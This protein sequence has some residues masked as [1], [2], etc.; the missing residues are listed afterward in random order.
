M[1]CVPRITSSVIFVSELSRSVEYY[2]DVFSCT[3]SVQNL[4]SALMLTPA[5]FQ[6]Y[7]IARGN[8]ASHLLG[9]IGYQCLIWT[10]ES[11]AELDEL[12]QV[13]S[14]R[15]HYTYSR[16]THGVRF[17]TTGDPD[18]IRILVAHPSPEELPRSVVDAVLYV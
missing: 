6:I 9:G 7:L 1:T 18:G 16:A 12:E 8:R 2:R 5:G 4:Y 13:M 17:L 14:N 10:V 15:G 11:A 3:A